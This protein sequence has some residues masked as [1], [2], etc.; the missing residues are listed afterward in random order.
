LAQLNKQLEEKL[1]NEIQT[2]RYPLRVAIPVN[3]ERERHKYTRLRPVDG[4]S[5]FTNNIID[6][7]LNSSLFL[8]SNYYNAGLYEAFYYGRNASTITG[9]DQTSIF[10][11]T[12]NPVDNNLTGALNANHNNQNSSV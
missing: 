9:I 5:P 6:Q 3:G 2:R 10:R 11:G 7:F 1:I 8:S 4:Q 12:P